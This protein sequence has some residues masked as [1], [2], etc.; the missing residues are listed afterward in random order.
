V[1][2][3]SPKYYDKNIYTLFQDEN[4]FEKWINSKI[5]WKFDLNTSK[6]FV[7][8]LLF[9]NFGILSGSFG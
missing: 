6:W 4:G 9:Y 7:N 3:E 5:I 2:T 1:T 8:F